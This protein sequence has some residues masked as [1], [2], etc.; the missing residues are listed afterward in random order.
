L[1]S[2]Q[3]MGKRWG[4]AARW[5]L[6]VGLTAWRYMWRTT[7]VHR[8]ELT[9]SIEQDRAPA[10]PAGFESRGVQ[11]VEDGEGALVHRI[12]RT[13]I[14]GS[15]MSAERLMAEVVI[16]LDRVA[17]SEFATFQKLHA[18]GPLAEG[19]EYVVRMPGPWDGPVIVID[20]Q[21]TSFRLATLE[22]HLEAGQI[23]FS[24][25]SRYRSL[26]FTIESWARSGDRL[27]DALYSH[28]RLAKEVQLHMWTSVLE[29]IVALA[30]GRM[31]G[32][33]TITTRRVDPH[34]FDGDAVELSD[35]RT[36]RRVR[37]LARLDSNFDPRDVDWQ[38]SDGGWRRDDLVEALPS[39]G[40]GPPVAG[41]SWQ[42]ARRLLDEY[43]LADPGVVSASYEPGRPLRGRDMLLRVRFG[44]LRFN[45]GVR[46]GEVHEETREV[47]G[48]QAL[49]FGWYYR[50]LRGH[51]EQG[52]MNYELWKWLD[53]G[54]VEFRLLAVSRAAQSGPLLLRTGF[55]LFG[56]RHQ[57]RF[58]RQ[59]CRRARRLTEA[60][61]ETN[62][63]AARREPRQ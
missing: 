26:T 10:L 8:W 46:V 23:E 38:R 11:G 25:H 61:L 62:A 50:T 41:G 39:E 12:Y 57:L 27:A 3:T 16:D 58:Y 17:P 37:A 18:D 35:P 5:P 14:V 22:G 60:Q 52:Q 36:R 42:V 31:E 40:S 48:R 56:R 19:D 55:R 49:V 53:T 32:G 51:F 59:V 54:D 28:L 15:P 44:P 63:A 30:G 45:V 9:G 47:D 29:K 33:I 2:K 21:P 7:A 6:G 1:S 20:A 4:T 34:R 43:Q 24:V 13:S